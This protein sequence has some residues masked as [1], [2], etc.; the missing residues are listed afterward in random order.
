MKQHLIPKSLEPSVQGKMRQ[1]GHGEYT[2]TQTTRIGLGQRRS[3]LIVCR[4]LP[5]PPPLLPLFTSFKEEFLLEKCEKQSP[6]FSWAPPSRG[7]DRERFAGRRARIRPLCAPW[8]AARTGARWAA[9]SAGALRARPRT[10]RP[11][12]PPRRPAGASQVLNTM[13]Y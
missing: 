9:W 2:Y 6:S 7:W 10:A 5:V 8:R 4:R 1:K 12:T 11:G 3:R 13:K